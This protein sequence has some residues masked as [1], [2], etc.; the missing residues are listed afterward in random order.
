MPTCIKVV[1]PHTCTSTSAHSHQCEWSVCVI[2]FKDE[3]ETLKCQLRQLVYSHIL[4]LLADT[5]N[6]A[7]DTAQHINDKGLPQWAGYHW[8]V[9]SED[10]MKRQSKT[11]ERPVVLSLNTLQE[12]SHTLRDYRMMKIPLKGTMLIHNTPGCYKKS[13]YVI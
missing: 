6:T 9:Y 4:K 1:L 12:P 5:W 11:E 2:N 13:T 10:Q 8:R 3:A 7:K